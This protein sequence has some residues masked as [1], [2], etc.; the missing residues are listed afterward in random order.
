MQIAGNLSEF[1]IAVDPPGETH[2][3]FVVYKFNFKTVFSVFHSTQKAEHSL[4]KAELVS[5]EREELGLKHQDPDRRLQILMSLGRV[6][7]KANK[8][9]YALE[10]FE[11]VLNIV[12][13]YF[14]IILINLIV[15]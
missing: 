12:Y 9:G 13:Q 11:K 1:I 14:V 7:L 3:G 5:R 2:L 6:S 8:T 4:K 10:S 15:K